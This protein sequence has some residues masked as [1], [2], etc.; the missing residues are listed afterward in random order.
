MKG[1]KDDYYLKNGSLDLTM[2]DG[3]TE[4]D[5][6]PRKKSQLAKDQ[7]VDKE[8]M[9]ELD[10][11]KQVGDKTY[12]GRYINLKIDKIPDF[13]GYNK[14][15][16]TQSEEPQEDIIKPY[17]SDEIHSVLR[18]MGAYLLEEEDEI[19]A[20]L[21][22]EVESLEPFKYPNEAITSK[23]LSNRRAR[24][25]DELGALEDLE[26]MGEL[27]ALGSLGELGDLEGLEDLD[28]G[29]ELEE[30]K[31]LETIE[32]IYLEPYSYEEDTKQV[33]V[34]QECSRE[35]DRQSFRLRQYELLEG[36]VLSDSIISSSGEYIGRQGEVITK[37]MI[38]LAEE[39]KC[40]IKMIMHSV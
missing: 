8:Q 30:R 4:E 28:G 24:E 39:K 13:E 1:Q 36:K 31:H 15:S 7:E 20:T 37:Y 10:N 22:Q 14:T 18:E 17:M 34:D 11:L 25:L 5:K 23:Y 21:D 6:E 9:L 32:D 38:Q 3:N 19:A 35:I 16:A 33:P 29:Q 2:L 40:M 12:G 27:G 26:E